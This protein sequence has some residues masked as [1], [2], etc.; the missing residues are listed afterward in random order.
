[1]KSRMRNRIVLL[2]FS[3]FVI[4]TG[5]LHSFSGRIYFDKDI[6]GISEIE[7]EFFFIDFEDGV[8]KTAIQFCSIQQ[9]EKDQPIWMVPIPADP[10]EVELTI[11][12]GF[13]RY[14]GFIINLYAKELLFMRFSFLYKSQF[15]PILLLRRIE[16][17]HPKYLMHWAFFMDS[18]FCIE[19]EQE[20]EFDILDP[21][22]RIEKMGITANSLMRGENKS[23]DGIKIHSKI[24]KD[25]LTAMLLGAQNIGSL[26]SFLCNENECLNEDL[27]V[28]LEEY[29]ANGFTLLFYG[30]T[31]AGELRI[32]QP[33]LYIWY[34]FEKDEFRE[35]YD[36]IIS[37]LAGG[38]EDKETWEHVLRIRRIMED[39]RTEKNRLCKIAGDYWFQGAEK[40]Y[41]NIS[42]PTTEI[43]FPLEV[44]S[45][46]GEKR[47][48][49]ILY[50]D[51]Y[52]NPIMQEGIRRES[53]VTYYYAL[54]GSKAYTKIKVFPPSKDLKQ[55][56]RVL[57]S[58]LIRVQFASFVCNFPSFLSPLSWK[59][60]WLRLILFT[61]VIFFP[62]CIAASYLS[63]LLAFRRSHVRRWKFALTGIL[64]IFTLVGIIIAVLLM[65]TRRIEKSEG[66]VVYTRKDLRKLW[67]IILFSV[68]FLAITAIIHL[69]LNAMLL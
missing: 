55:D 10:E 21:E 65:R 43:I 47:I 25:G 59:C 45:I 3:V 37:A 49:Q 20:R 68:F 58:M 5:Q 34:L 36:F 29:L 51:G 16:R 2:V 22:V 46:Y 31:D 38:I 14:E 24:E 63:S 57:K 27:K 33:I 26:E 56:L 39:S 64:N 19:L 12:K 28:I 1:M 69:I 7:Q 35:A 32:E 23:F 18:L 11:E 48:S 67:F 50:V 13:K 62:I 60:I 4:A 40:E 42:F 30:V 15:Y 66:E 54:A 61:V 52:V 17:F 8:Q 44:N 41:I 9:F 53:R 6:E